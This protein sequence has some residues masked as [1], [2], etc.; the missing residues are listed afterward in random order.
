VDDLNGLGLA[1]GYYTNGRLAGSFNSLPVY[2]VGAAGFASGGLTAGAIGAGVPNP[3]Q[4]LPGLTQNQYNTIIQNLSPLQISNLNNLNAC[5]L[6]TFLT[7]TVP[8]QQILTGTLTPTQI[9]NIIDNLTSTQFINLINSLNVTQLQQ[10]G[11][12]PMPVGI[13]RTPV[14]D[15]NYVAKLSDRVISYTAITAPRTV[16]LPPAAGFPGG[17]ILR[18]VDESGSA[19]STNTISFARTGSDT[20]DNGSG[21]V[22][23]IN[24]AY[25]MGEAETNGTSD[26]TVRA[27]PGGGGGNANNTLTNYTGTTT[28]A[29]ATVFDVT[30]AKGLH[31][32]FAITNTGGANNFNATLTGTDMFGTVTNFNVSGIAPNAQVAYPFDVSNGFGVPPLKELLFQIQDA[33]GG[34]H[35]TYNGYVS[36]VG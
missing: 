24:L 18:L 35:T 10:L 16:T 13:N 9:T 3:A 5:Q 26:W 25:G 33:V 28:A 6:Q 36:L 30:N 27:F 1:P 7:L 23:A 14:N 22:T 15:Q 32:S 21:N 4:G 2:A 31:G 8:Q 11:N 19:S 29:L 17:F 34:S 20:I 12:N